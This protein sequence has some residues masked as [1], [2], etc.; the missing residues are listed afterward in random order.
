MIYVAKYRGCYFEV[1]FSV[2]PL[3]WLM[4]D[5]FPELQSCK[6]VPD[7]PLIPTCAI[8]TPTVINISHMSAVIII[9]MTA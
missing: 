4:K 7:R 8:T 9:L 5:I 6:Y 1:W 2:R 3:V